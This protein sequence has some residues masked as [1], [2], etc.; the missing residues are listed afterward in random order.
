MLS[1]LNNNPPD[2]DYINEKIGDAINYLIIIEG[3]LKERIG[4]K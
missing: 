1:D 3:L 4:D 2:E